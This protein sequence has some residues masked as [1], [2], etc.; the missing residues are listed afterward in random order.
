MLELNNVSRQAWNS[1]ILTLGSPALG[2]Q[3][4]AAVPDFLYLM[5]SGDMNSDLCSCA[6]NALLTEP[7]G[8]APH[9]SP[10]LLKGTSL[11][12]PR[13]C[14]VP[15]RPSPGKL[16]FEVSLESTCSEHLGVF[17]KRRMCTQIMM[18]L[19]RSWG[20]LARCVHNSCRTRPSPARAVMWRGVLFAWVLSWTDLHPLDGLLGSGVSFLGSC[21]VSA[22]GRGELLPSVCPGP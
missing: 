15:K 9:P 5:G 19:I 18:K 3:A 8:P 14:V 2:L 4:S 16:L 11:P 6:T 13:V 1:L 17:Q 21:G 22:Q 12:G 10:T 20:Y 7:F